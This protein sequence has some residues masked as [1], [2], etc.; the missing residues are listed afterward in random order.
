MINF[1]YLI[2]LPRNILIAFGS[3]TVLNALLT[4]FFFFT[5]TQLNLCSTETLQRHFI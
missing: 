1:S 5:W 3:P 2:L 4:N